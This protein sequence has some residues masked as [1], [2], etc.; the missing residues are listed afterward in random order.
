MSIKLSEHL[1]RAP[2]LLSHTGGNERV[3]CVFW[4]GAPRIGLQMALELGDMLWQ[5]PSTS[6]GYGGGSLVAQ[7]CLTLAA[8]RTDCSPPSPSVHGIPGCEFLL[9]TCHFMTWLKVN[10]YIPSN[11]RLYETGSPTRMF[12]RT[13]RALTSFITS[14]CIYS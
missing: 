9:I 8:P 14:C 7:L 13:S 4:P 6:T 2:L 11:R 12:L 1:H 3:G 5:L 10:E